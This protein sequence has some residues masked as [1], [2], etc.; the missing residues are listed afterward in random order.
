[1]RNV[2]T[3]LV[4]TKVLALFHDPPWKPWALA[5]SRHY[6]IEL[7]AS[8]AEE[9]EHLEGLARTWRALSSISRAA[10]N[11]LKR[12]DAHPRSLKEVID[13]LIELSKREEDELIPSEIGRGIEGEERGEDVE[14]LSEI[15]DSL[16][17]VF[18]EL[19]DENVLEKELS[20]NSSPEDPQRRGLTGH[21]YH[22]KFLLN[23]I[24]KVAC[25]L[26]FS[27]IYNELHFIHKN[28]KEG[29]DLWEKVK[30]ADV[31][32]STLD[33][34]LLNLVER[35]LDFH[36]PGKF[37]K[38]AIFVNPFN[39]RFTSKPKSVISD[40]LIAAF[41]I[42]YVLALFYSLKKM[43]S[44]GSEPD[45]MDFYHFAF[46]LLEPIWYYVVRYYPPADTRI[47][48]HTVFDHLNA[49]LAM[50]NW[51]YMDREVKGIYAET[52]IPSAQAFIEGSRRIRDLWASSWL[53][54]YFSWL[55]VRKFVEEYGPDV[56]A[57]PPARFHPFYAAYLLSKL[58]DE[59]VTKSPSLKFIARLL[60]VPKGW[61]IDPTVPNRNHLV[62]PPHTERVLGSYVRD[63]VLEGWRKFARALVD[64][65]EKLFCPIS[66]CLNDD[67]R[68]VFEEEQRDE[69]SESRLRQQLKVIELFASGELRKYLKYLEPPFAFTYSHVSVGKA[70]NE[71]KEMVEKFDWSA[72]EPKCFS[73]GNCD[74]LRDELAKVLLFDYLQ[75]KIVGKAE[76]SRIGSK[77]GRNYLRLAKTL[78]DNGVTG[79]CHVCRI[80]VPVVDGSAIKRLVRKLSLR[81]DDE[82]KR[83]IN[84]AFEEK[85]CPYCLIKRLTRDFLKDIG[86]DL[87]NLE[88]PDSVYVRLGRYSIDL[89]S[90]RRQLAYEEIK[91]FVEELVEEAL[92]NGELYGE[93]KRWKDYTAPIPVLEQSD[94]DELV[95]RCRNG[96]SQEECRDLVRGAESLVSQAAHNK[97]FVEEVGIEGALAKFLEKVQES[98]EVNR[99]RR[100]T[101]T[102]IADGDKMGSGVLSGKL[103]MEPREYAELVY[104]V[105]DDLVKSDLVNAFEWL[106]K[107]Y[108]RALSRNLSGLELEGKTLVTT[109]SYYYTVSRA[110]AAQATFDRELVE[111]FG[112]VL[113]Y[114]GGDD[115]RA[116]VPP[117]L[118]VK[119]EKLFSALTLVEGIRKSYWGQRFNGFLS[120]YLSKLD[121]GWLNS[122]S[123]AKGEGFNNAPYSRNAY[124]A[125]RAFGRSTVL[126]Y[127]DVKYPM[128]YVMDY[129]HKLIEGK[130]K[131]KVLLKGVELYEKDFLVV[132]SYSSVPSVLP[133][134]DQGGQ[135]RAPE[136][137][138]GLLYAVEK[139]WV[140]AS[141]LTDIE[142]F[143]QELCLLSQ[144]GEDGE[145][146]VRHVL[147]RNLVHASHADAVERLL[148]LSYGRP[149][150]L[151]IGEIEE[152]FVE[153]KVGRLKVYVPSN[154]LVTLLS[155][156]ELCKPQNSEKDLILLPAIEIARAARSTRLAW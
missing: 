126:Y 51:T 24:M 5:V 21:E 113:V 12:L 45:L 102:V 132:A 8:S 53:L 115:L 91:R 80:G 18:C 93:L 57:K 29:S 148:S 13:R 39:P 87:I 124:P 108:E 56:L 107:E 143:L 59:D 88:M 156:V 100:V 77:V 40:K 69:A 42:S 133:F 7:T 16:K 92:E 65:L 73:H 111:A 141:Y 97:R 128:W 47:P 58:T 26:G 110:L 10:S 41:I 76:K 134:T 98:S 27:D 103:E 82:A 109:P 145:A 130:D 90:S 125:L 20:G 123:G 101:S 85:L 70:L 74:E 35:S 30:R 11:L 71:L 46:S 68:K 6:K 28:F 118:R 112:G 4:R 67:L 150:P 83:V 106:V 78:H 147:E 17:K 38:D 48:H 131:F 49:T 84:N 52:Q 25:E 2:E 127:F 94:Y 155:T 62:L 135:S 105:G 146:I 117:V 120:D 144:M 33:R 81:L 149:W 119:G 55:T 72:L 139:K 104:N 75:I 15:L 1:M 66:K 44:R 140:S 122:L 99:Y 60:G 79:N 3:E 31:L 114:A 137:V 116:V 86:K 64:Y 95:E 121:K 9:V 32:A 34:T 136:S 152:A 23:V 142:A 129:T 19:K 50:V 96:R 14:T 138:I 154:E 43:K 61:P 37:N 36:H 153:E 89:Q 63:S 54:S 151:V 22:G